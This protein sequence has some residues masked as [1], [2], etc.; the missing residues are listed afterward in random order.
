MRITSAGHV[1]VGATTDPGS[2]TKGA[3]LYASGVG[4]FSAISQPVVYANRITDDGVIF[5][6]QR[7]G[8]VVGSIGTNGGS[9][10]RLYIASGDTGLDFESNT[11]AIRPCL[12]SGGGRDNAIDFG[13]PDVRFRTAYITNG[14]VTG[15]DLNDKQDIEVLTEAETRVAIACRGLLRKW[16]W[17]DSV[18][19][20]GDAARTHFGIVAQELKSAFES[21]GLDAG[22]YSMFIW[23]EWWELS[24]PYVDENGLE[25]VRI[26]TY[27]KEE[28]APEGA[29]RKERMGIQYSELLAFMIAVL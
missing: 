9:P 3:A 17:K 1:F 24:V 15:S 23:N 13:R 21:E 29:I 18:A 20:K 8:T 26:D 12:G 28:D 7:S 6:F 19:E 25:K 11:D 22:R 16:R 14:V 10:T 2:T 4:F 27:Q 5:E